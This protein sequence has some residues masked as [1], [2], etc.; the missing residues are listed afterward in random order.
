[1][2]YKSESCE[3]CL[4]EK[5]PACEVACLFSAIKRDENGKVVIDQKD[6]TGCGRC[7]EYVKLKG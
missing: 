3:G 1:M 7:V 4:S 6:Y 2:I 5:S